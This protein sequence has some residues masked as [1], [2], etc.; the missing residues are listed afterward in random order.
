MSAERSCLTR[1]LRRADSRQSGNPGRRM[2]EILEEIFLYYFLLQVHV[3][4]GSL[5]AEHRAVCVMH[6]SFDFYQLSSS[7]YNQRA[8]E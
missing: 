7:H 8:R 2:Q 6:S 3:S 4:T 1:R 5:C